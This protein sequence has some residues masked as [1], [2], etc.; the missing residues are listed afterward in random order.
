MQNENRVWSKNVN[1]YYTVFKLEIR[2]G[3]KLRRQ[4]IFSGVY[5]CT[6]VTSVGLLYDLHVYCSLA[7][8]SAVRSAKPNN[9]FG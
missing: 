9:Q 7:V 2:N 1:A 8:R 5:Y 6:L 3:K 4:L